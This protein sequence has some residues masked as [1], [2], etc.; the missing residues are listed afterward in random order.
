MVPDPAEPVT[1]N[2]PHKRLLSFAPAWSLPAD[3]PDL[4][5]WHKR[6]QKG[7]R[8]APSLPG[9][10]EIARTLR[11]V[12]F[13]AEGPSEAPGLNLLVIGGRP[14]FLLDQTEG[15]FLTCASGGDGVAPQARRTDRSAKL[16]ADA[17][18]RLRSE[19]PQHLAALAPMMAE[20]AAGIMLH[21]ANK[22]LAGLAAPAGSPDLALFEW[23]MAEGDVARSAARSQALK[24]YPFL[25][26]MMTE[27]GVS[28]LSPITAAIDERRSLSLVL[29]E[30]FQTSPAVVKEAARLRP[31]SLGQGRFSL[32]SKGALQAAG[33]LQPNLVPG[34]GIAP[35]DRA[36]RAFL[37]IYGAIQTGRGRLLDLET[38]TIGGALWSRVTQDQARDVRGRVLRV[39]DCLDAVYQDL[40]V[41]NLAIHGRQM[42][43]RLGR[44]EV[45]SILGYDMAGP[46]L[47]GDRGFNAL[48][49]M[50]RR[51]EQKRAE[52][53][54]AAL[55]LGSRFADW[56][57]LSA[58]YHDLVTDLRVVP[59]TSTEALEA[60][61]KGQGHC[62]GMG[63]ADALNRPGFAGG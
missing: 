11:G 30:A 20:K 44:A 21:R 16:L 50:A 29:E 58:E 48:E 1:L 14:L 2:V 32:L 33:E 43:Q 5:R 3:D 63:Y 19:L 12:M 8:K 23:L 15:R 60:E 47:R 10:D 6:R 39:L 18:R 41:P 9:R 25:V 46:L 42:G 52:I 22:D 53:E 13:V 7:R 55:R 49:D 56:P 17:E 45:E 51:W 40:L 54:S 36:W 59:L 57:A 28:G 62:M 35:R 24:A 38:F 31:R 37:D 27:R 26:A 4:T 34:R 61:G